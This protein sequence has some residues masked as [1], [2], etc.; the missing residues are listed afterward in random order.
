MALTGDGFTYPKVMS[1]LGNNNT[2]QTIST[3]VKFDYRSEMLL[4]ISD[5][6]IHFIWHGSLQSV[7]V[8]DLERD[9]R[10]LVR[11]FIILHW[12]CIFE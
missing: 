10:N 3:M 9:S 8:N 12:C 5:T 2:G 1:A 6:E 11:C 4:K 7:C